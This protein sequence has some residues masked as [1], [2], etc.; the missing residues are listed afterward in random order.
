MSPHRWR[1]GASGGLTDLTNH[2]YAALAR[3]M[4]ASIRWIENRERE[5]LQYND[6]DDEEPTIEQ[7]IA[8]R[9]EDAQSEWHHTQDTRDV[10]AIL[11]TLLVLLAERDER[12]GT[13]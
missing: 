2:P 11:Q 5:R 3:D 10:R 4:D 1:G 6:D 9:L 8:A 7:L 12:D 13:S